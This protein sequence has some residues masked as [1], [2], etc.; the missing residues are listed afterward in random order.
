MNAN[1]PQG[2]GYR[3]RRTFI[4]TLTLLVI[5]TLGGGVVFL[6]GKINASTFTLAQDNGQLVVMKGRNLP[7]GAAP[8]RP[9]DP[10]LADAYAPLP[11]EGQ[12]VTTLTMQRFGDR[13]ELDRALFPLLESLARPRIAAEDPARVAQG[14][15]YLRRAEKLSGITE[16]QRRTLQVLLTDIAYHQ[17]RQKLEDARRLVSEGLAQLKLAAESQNR[18]ARSANQMLSTVGPA[19]RDLEE[20]LRRAVHTQSAPRE[21]EPAPS[22]PTPQPPSQGTSPAPQ[23]EGQPPSQAPSGGDAGPTP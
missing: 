11:L 23:T 6:L 12:D 3:A 16:E 19:A 7:T 13:D 4:R 1:S 5:L 14:L 22:A 20:A 2:F 18:N 10:R 17:A 8:Y 21:P 15:Y 9:G